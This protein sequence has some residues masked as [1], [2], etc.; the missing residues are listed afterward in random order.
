MLLSHMTAIETILL[1]QS[2]AAK[3]AGH[4]NIRGG[5]REWFLR[6][7]LSNHLPS[8]LEIGQGEIIDYNS[9]PSPAKGDYRNQ[10]DI[11]IYRKGLPKLSYSETDKAYLIEGVVASIEIKSDLTKSEFGKSCFASKNN[12][13]LTQL[14]IV[15]TYPKRTR[16][17]LFTYVVA[18]NGPTNMQTVSG[19]IPELLASTS[20]PI[21]AE[22]LIDFVVVLGKGVLWNLEAFPEF[23]LPSNPNGKQ[24]AF[25]EQENQNLFTMFVHM[26]TWLSDNT[27]SHSLVQ[28]ASNASYQNIHFF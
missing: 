1:A 27:L 21:D 9:V 23:L 18:F 24:W 25:V 2:L 8:T 28:Y 7:F 17:N 19:W 12:K 16:R 13:S 3:N 10:V 4:P 26:M 14:E 15:N 11:V 20:N 6:D 22:D 5:P